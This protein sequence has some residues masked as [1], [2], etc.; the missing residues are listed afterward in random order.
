M[1]TPFY[2]L[3]LIFAVVTFY[4]SI[5]AEP[6]LYLSYEIKQEI[7]IADATTAFNAIVKD[8]MTKHGVAEL[9]TVELSN[10]LALGADSHLDLEHPGLAALSRRC[11]KAG[12]LPRG[13]CIIL[14][15][16]AWTGGPEGEAALVPMVY[17]FVF[18]T[19]RPDA[20]FAA[21]PSPDQSAECRWLPVRLTMMPELSR[22]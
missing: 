2:R 20:N 1:P 14:K 15:N 22:K 3:A 19:T 6:P 7:P 18:I 4:P 12:S 16:G 17:V 11:F 13:S 21:V 5:K 8:W 10:A 9:K